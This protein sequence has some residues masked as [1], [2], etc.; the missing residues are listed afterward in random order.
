MM[1][2]SCVCLPAMKKK[3]RF[4]CYYFFIVFL[5][6]LK[7]SSSNVCVCAFSRIKNSIFNSFS[8]F[9]HW[10][11]DGSNR[12]R[13]AALKRK[14]A[15]VEESNE[16]QTVKRL[17]V[18]AAQPPP[19][20]ASTS[21]ARGEQNK[22]HSISE[23]IICPHCR[24]RNSNKSNLRTQ[25]KAIHEEVIHH[26]CTECDYGA[27]YLRDLRTH[28][29]NEHG[30]NA[31]KRR[32]IT[33]N[34]GCTQCGNKYSA[35]QNLN[36]HIKNEHS[37]NSEKYKCKHCDYAADDDSVIRRHEATAHTYTVHYCNKCNYSKCA[38]RSVE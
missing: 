3:K 13:D 31:N 38:S 1:S 24:R 23:N 30:E 2:S 16:M 11:G 25:I 35:L 15:T 33:R 20:T 12:R 17:K 27:H 37:K 29:E 28:V 4:V 14:R 32:Q 10:Q 6:L 7:N 8:I 22:T 26:R 18:P 19:P 5:F 34:Y 9:L 21:A 36:R